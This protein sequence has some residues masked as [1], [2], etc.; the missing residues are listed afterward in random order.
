M[1][2][3]KYM[4]EIIIFFAFVAGVVV[5][6][7]VGM[8]PAH[9]KVTAGLGALATFTLEADSGD[10][11]KTSP[12]CEVLE[13]WARAIPTRNGGVNRLPYAESFDGRQT[14]RIAGSGNPDVGS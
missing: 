3:G 8:K 14:D 4:I 9:L 13:S 12:P 5:P 11:S 6:P 2:E 7:L 1:I 10:A